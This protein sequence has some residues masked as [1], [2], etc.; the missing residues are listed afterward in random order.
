METGVGAAE[1]EDEDEEDAAIG[2]NEEEETAQVKTGVNAIKGNEASFVRM[3]LVLT[4][5]KKSMRRRRMLSR[6]EMSGH[7]QEGVW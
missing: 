4:Q 7:G 6:R 1:D 3:K 5:S 2:V